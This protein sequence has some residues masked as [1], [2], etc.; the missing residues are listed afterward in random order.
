VLVFISYVENGRPVEQG[1]VKMFEQCIS[2][3]KAL[4]ALFSLD[5]HA[6]VPLSGGCSVQVWLSWFQTTTCYDICC[7]LG[8]HVG[9]IDFKQNVQRLC[10]TFHSI[11]WR[12][13][14]NRALAS[15]FE[16]S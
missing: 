10:H 16:V 15:S 9:I 13:N 2:T 5:R 11:Q 12:C 8:R 7:A 14:S 4:L 6:A 3:Y 1:L